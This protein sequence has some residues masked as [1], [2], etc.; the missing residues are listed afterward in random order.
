[1]RRWRR[2]LPLAVLLG[3]SNLDEG[4]AGVVALELRLPDPTTVEVGE[5]L[6]LR[7]VALNRDGDSVAAPIV[8][9]TPDNTITVGEATG[10]LTGVAPGTG[11]VQ[12]SSGSLSSELVSFTVLAPADTIV[13]VSDSIVPAPA[14]PGTAGPLVV[15][16]DSFD[17]AGPLQNRPVIFEITRPTA[18]PFTVTLPGGVVIDTLTTAADGTASVIVTL[19][20]GAPVPDSVF[21]EVRASR[22]RGDVVPGSGQRFIVLYQ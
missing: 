21:V 7:A 19:T 3:C 18:E 9:R 10:L 8:W 20:A 15:R 16:L 4:E 14:D 2:L 5:T 11:R 1:M 13:L 17:P 12:A 6:Q 22:T